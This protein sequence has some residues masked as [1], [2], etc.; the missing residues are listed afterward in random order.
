MPAKNRIKEYFE[1]GYYHLYNRGVDRRTIFSD[2]KDYSVFLDYL[3]DYLTPKDSTKL[4]EIL[5]NPT[6]TSA[7]KDHAGK[8]LRLNN[9]SDSIQLLT[10]C[11]MPNHF[12]LLIKQTH[13]R[14]IE[15]FMK[16]L[17]TRYVRYYNHR[18]APRSGNLF[19]DSYKAVRIISNEQ[20]L[21]LSRYIHRNP[22]MPGVPLLDSPQP[23]S[24]KN[25]LG[26]FH[27][28]WIQPNEILSQVSSYS[29]F[30]DINQTS[31]IIYQLTLDT[32]T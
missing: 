13:H 7:D 15:K 19:E 22:F 5:S 3:K 9:F 20:L 27:Q 28:D 8:L 1:N 25:Y 2:Q 14:S 26:L 12:H 23:T 30:I 10:Y 4:L 31:E 29:E 6:T 21:H 16:S 32:N 18:H 11:L 24:L 17:L